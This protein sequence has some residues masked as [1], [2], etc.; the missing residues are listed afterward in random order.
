MCDQVYHSWTTNRTGWLPLLTVTNK[1]RISH[2][3]PSAVHFTDGTTLADS[4]VTIFLGTGYEVRIP[5]LRTLE[6]SSSPSSTTLTTN[7]RRVRPLFKHL[8]PLDPCFPAGSLAIVGL[9]VNVSYC[10]LAYIQSLVVAHAIADPAMLPS[11]AEMTADQIGRA[12]V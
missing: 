5:F 8:I 12:H 10:A 1:P 4:D 11:R 7:L 3:T 2:F 6:I 9:P